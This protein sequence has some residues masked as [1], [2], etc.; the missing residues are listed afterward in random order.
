MKFHLTKRSLQSLMPA[1]AALAFVSALMIGVAPV[2]AAD[3]ITLELNKLEPQDKSCRAYLVVGNNGQ[4]V[5]Q[6]FK[7]DLVMF[8]PDGVIGKRFALDLAPIKAGK[9]TV[10][11]FDLDGVGCDKVGSLLINDVM[12]CK[13]EAGAA[14]DCLSRLELSSLGQVKISK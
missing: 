9:K 1:A 12:D 3:P 6:T 11:L 13:T 7:L 8:Q 5:Y 10:K 4:T 2:R 14:D